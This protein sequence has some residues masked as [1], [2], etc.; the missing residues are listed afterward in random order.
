MRAASGGQISFPAWLSATY[1]TKPS[2]Y[3]MSAS[4]TGDSYCKHKFVFVTRLGAIHG[5]RQKKTEN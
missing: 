4:S 1:A 3:F 2:K 5:R